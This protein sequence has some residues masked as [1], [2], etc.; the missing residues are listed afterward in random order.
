MEWNETQRKVA[1]LI[2]K[3]RADNK[4]GYDLHAIKEEMSPDIAASDALI[5]KVAGSL[6]ANNWEIVEEQGE[7]A[8]S[9]GERPY[10]TV[11][12]AKAAP[13][14]FTIDDYKIKLDPI[15]MLK[16]YQPEP[17]PQPGHPEPGHPKPE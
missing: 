9:G 4:S 2:L 11:K 1:E 17:G 14:V 5:S 10:A 16:S 15:F 8:P 12:S 3:H 6:R 7:P 13:L